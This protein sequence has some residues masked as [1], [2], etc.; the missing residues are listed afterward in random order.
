MN[1]ILRKAKDG[2]NSAK[3]AIIEM[4]RMMVY[5]IASKYYS[6]FL[7]IND[8]VQE[9]MIGILE[10][11]NK[12]DETRNAS[13]CTVVYIYITKYIKKAIDSNSGKMGVHVP[14][15]TFYEKIKLNYKIVELLQENQ[16]MINHSDE[17]LKALGIT[18]KR[19]DELSGHQQNYDEEVW[20]KVK[21]E[22]DQFD[23]IIDIEMTLEKIFSVLTDEEREFITTRFGL[24]GK[25]KL[26]CVAHSKKLNCSDQTILNNTKRILAKIR[27]NID[28]EKLR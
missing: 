23:E 15:Q 21:D 2:D 14:N 24:F 22:T 12:Y 1:E 8:L 9:G 5:K 28:I 19:W 20:K 27:Q 18:R 26:G 3:L 25:E 6:S 17:C 7:D 13:F 10:A 11:I 4:Y 16:E